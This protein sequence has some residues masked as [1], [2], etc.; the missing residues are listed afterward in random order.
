LDKEIAQGRILTCT[1]YA[2]EGDVE[3]RVG[4]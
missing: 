4:D 1:G 3:L 2:I